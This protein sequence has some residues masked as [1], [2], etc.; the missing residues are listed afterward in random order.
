LLA[1]VHISSMKT[2][3][4]WLGPLGPTEIIASFFKIII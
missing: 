3:M 4:P 1:E 2:S